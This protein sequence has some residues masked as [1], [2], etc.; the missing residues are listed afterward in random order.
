MGK[1]FS[2]A[3]QAWLKRLVDAYRDGK[4]GQ[5]SMTDPDRGND[6]QAAELFIA[7]PQSVA[8]IPAMSDTNLPGKAV[9]DFLKIMFL[10]DDRI[11]AVPDR[12]RS[13]YNISD[14]TLEQT[15]LLVHH[16][17]NGPWIASGDGGAGGGGE[18][19]VTKYLGV[20]DGTL[21]QGGSATMSIWN[22]DPL[23]DSGD[24]LTVWDWFLAVGEDLAGGTRVKVDLFS[25]KWYVTAAGCS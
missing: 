19:V 6:P 8:G 17:K 12:A 11:E 1:L 20:L 14:T 5:S 15:W 22:D 3:D 10:D 2:D 25:G 4:F 9:C 24:N 13:V 16:A 21:E 7:K 23:E 18:A